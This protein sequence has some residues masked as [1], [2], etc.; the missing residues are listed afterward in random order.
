MSLLEFFLAFL[1]L[2]VISSGA[3]VGW[4]QSTRGRWYITPGGKWKTTGMIFRY[5]SLFFEQYQKTKWVKYEAAG[6]KEKFD[7]LFK[8]HTG[9]ALKLNL[10]DGVLKKTPFEMTSTDLAVIE[11]ALLCRADWEGDELVLT[12]EEPVYLFPEWIEKPLSSCP[13]CMSGPYGTTI[14]LVFLK[15]ERNA[16]AW[17]DY[18]LMAKISGFVLFLLALSC[19]NTFISKQLKL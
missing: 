14:W 9:V 1:I 15:L 6:L 12:V 7:L 3:I 2:T 13:T 19:L 17:T 10:T 5:W 18:A 8:T 11:Q 4:Y 16:F